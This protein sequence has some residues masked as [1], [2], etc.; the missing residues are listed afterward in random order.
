MLHENVA[1]RPAVHPSAPEAKVYSYA[2]WST[3]EQSKGDTLRRQ[4]DAAHAWARAKGLELDER[5]SYRDEGVSAYR[6]KNAAS[7]DLKEFLEYC[8]RGL[9]PLGSF[10]LVE[11]FDRLSRRD[12]WDTLDLLRPIINAGITIVTLCDGQEFDRESMR[13]MSLIVAIMVSMRAHE[14]SATKGRRV[15]AAW[16]EKR[17]RVRQNPAER[18]TSRGPSWL[19]PTPDG[20]WK[21]AEGKADTVRRIYT[22]TLAGEGEHRIAA[23]FNK[24]GVPVLSNGQHWH[25]STVSKVLRNLAVI[26]TLVPGRIEYIDGR[27]CHVREA[28]VPDAFPAVVSVADWLAVRALKDGKAG[29]VRGRHAGKPLAHVLAGLAKCPAC[30]GS[31]SRV[32]KGSRSK[33]GRPKLVCNAAKSKAGCR[34]V[35]VPVEGVEE[36]FFGDWGALFEDI[37][38]DDVTNQLNALYRDQQAAIWGTEDHLADL[39]TAHERAPSE[40]GARLLAKAEAELRSMRAALEDL[41]ER[42]CMTD[43]GLIRSRIDHLHT[44]LEPEAGEGSYGPPAR[45]RGAINAMLKVLFSGVAV[46]YETGQLRFQ[47]RQGGE[48]RLTYAWVD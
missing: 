44:L 41:D 18:L 22:M 29:A 45:D 32:S 10:L 7:G 4:L 39:A 38:A 40:A 13:G 47:W 20:G 30:G 36:A 19:L 27:R 11:S 14:E 1:R 26:G 35:S 31:M 15:A 16:Q 2:R 34:Y 24:E 25:R 12:P 46:D 42:R 3:E 21:E 48:A 5:L 6:G 37:P 43:R 23:T 28:P 17:R 8:E 33:A 9:I